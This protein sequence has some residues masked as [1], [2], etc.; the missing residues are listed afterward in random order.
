MHEKW[1][2]KS[3]NITYGQ[4]SGASLEFLQI[5]IMFHKK[6][7]LQQKRKTE[8]L[9]HK[10]PLPCIFLYLNIFLAKYFFGIDTSLFGNSLYVFVTHVNKISPRFRALVCNL[11][12][13]D[14]K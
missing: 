10:F 14:G 8:V 9:P 1:Y 12:K 4:N 5:K 2:V 13:T 3:R 11:Q 7:D 6:L